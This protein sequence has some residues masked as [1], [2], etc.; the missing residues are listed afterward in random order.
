MLIL[1]WRRDSASSFHT[2]CPP[3]F[4]ANHTSLPFGRPQGSRSEP[5]KTIVGH[6][7]ILN[8]NRVTRRS[9]KTKTSFHSPNRQSYRGV[10]ALNGQCRLGCECGVFLSD[11]PCHLSVVRV[12]TYFIDALPR[13]Y[14]RAATHS[15][16]VS[17][18]PCLRVAAHPSTCRTYP[19]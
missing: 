18:P 6:T 8:L 12:V 16:H 11:G 10:P 14:L 13:P 15:I 4:N 7:L 1:Q 3:P 5:K 2:I 17:H 9:L 19:R